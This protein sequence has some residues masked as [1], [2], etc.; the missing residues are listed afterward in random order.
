VAEGGSGYVRRRV[1]YAALDG[2]QRMWTARA[3]Q[4]AAV[5]LDNYVFTDR[6]HS[7]DGLAPLGIMPRRKD[8]LL[9]E[10]S[11]FVEPS[12]GDLRRIEGRLS[13]APSFW[14]RRVDI[15][16]RYERMEGVR[17]P[18]AIESVAHLLVAG[19]STFK[20]TYQYESING[21]RVGTPQPRR[22][23]RE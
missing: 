5:T 17:V 6:T 7:T 11:I 22:P 10:G 15:V 23:S 8:V 16:R 9:V 20:M 1:L 12:D 14:T 13:K 3:P 4:R 2:E 18:V 19:E 21:Q